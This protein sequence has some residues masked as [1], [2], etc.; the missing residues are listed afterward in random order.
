MKAEIVNFLK[1]ILMKMLAVLSFASVTA[2]SVGI[3]YFVMKKPEKVFNCE[4]SFS[5]KFALFSPTFAGGCF[6]F[7]FD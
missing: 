3:T 6:R 2:I 5:E 4:G 7:V 1:K